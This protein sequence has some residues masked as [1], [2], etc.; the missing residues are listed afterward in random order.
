MLDDLGLL[1]ALVWLIERYT[2]QTGI[3]VQFEHSGI[4]RRFP[5]EIETA[6]FRLVQEALTNVARHAAVE[7]VTVRAWAQE[8]TLGVQVAD[9]G[10]GFSPDEALGRAD[11]S[12]LIGMRERAAALGGTLTIDSEPGRGVRLTAELPIVTKSISAQVRV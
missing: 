3:K 9:E 1:P 7:Q 10:K 4:D 5:P 11:S 2:A 6:A 12:G 8:S